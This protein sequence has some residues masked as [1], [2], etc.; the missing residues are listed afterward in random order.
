MSIRAIYFEE[1]NIGERIKKSKKQFIWK[2]ELDGLQHTIEFLVSKLT[3]KKKVIQDGITLLEQKKLTKS[4][5]FPFNINKHMC[6][7]IYNLNET[8]L[9][10]DNNPFETLY[11]GKQLKEHNVASVNKRPENA[12][13]SQTTYISR[14]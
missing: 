8:D 2:F 7:I 14:K 6:V 13:R 12:N 3:G 10:I 1:K 5:Q 9:R 4:F 11:Q